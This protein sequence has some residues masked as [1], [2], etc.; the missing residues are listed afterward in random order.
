MSRMRRVDPS[1][2]LNASRS[3]SIDV[4]SPTGPDVPSFPGCLERGSESVPLPV[5]ALDTSASVRT[6]ETRAPQRRR[7]RSALVT[8]RSLLSE[9]RSRRSSLACKRRP[10]GAVSD[11]RKILGQLPLDLRELVVVNR[12]RCTR[13]SGTSLV[14]WEPRRVPPWFLMLRVSAQQ[15]ASAKDAPT[16]ARR[17]RRDRAAARRARRRRNADAPAAT[18]VDDRFGARASRPARRTPSITAA[19]VGC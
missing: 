8:L 17:D 11:L 15:H 4:S 13:L 7:A 14:P 12:R 1:S 10:L 9:P 3:I 6:P 5:H 2:S 18:S 16:G 19:R